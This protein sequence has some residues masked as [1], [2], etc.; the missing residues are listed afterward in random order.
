MGSNKALCMLER[1][2][3]LESIV[4]SLIQ[5]GVEKIVV[6]VGSES[7]RV[8]H[9]HANLEVTWC[10]NA[11]WPTTY[12]LES[13]CC[14]LGMIPPGFWVL[15]WPV[16]CVG[17][18]VGD[19]RRLI[20]APLSPLTALSY[21]NVPGHPLRFSPLAIKRLRALSPGLRTLRDF[22]SSQPLSFID[23]H[24]EALMNCNDRATLATFLEKRRNGKA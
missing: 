4:V 24:E 15:H 11:H 8:M 17:V 3:F 21:G 12:M 20:E 18:T 6:V 2:T 23:A 13:L 19:L 9:C 14:G 1:E 16:D 10:F 22:V 7:E 5:A